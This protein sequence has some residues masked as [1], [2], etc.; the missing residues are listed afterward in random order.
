MN[1]ITR[2]QIWW[3]KYFHKSTHTDVKYMGGD[4]MGETW[5]KCCKRPECEQWIHY[6]EGWEVRRGK[7]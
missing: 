7:V 1:F 2:L 3:C 5:Y 4:M 6:Y